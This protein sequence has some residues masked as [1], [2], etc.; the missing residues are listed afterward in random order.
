MQIFLS[1][2]VTGEDTSPCSP[3]CKYSKNF[4]CPVYKVETSPGSTRDKTTVTQIS[5]SLVNIANPGQ[6]PG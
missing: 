2:S 5:L 3:S 1:Y 4:I 6:T